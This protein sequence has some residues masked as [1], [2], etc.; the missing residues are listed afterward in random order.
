MLFWSWVFFAVLLGLL[1]IIGYLFPN[2]PEAL[3]NCLLLWLFLRWS[4]VYT[5]RSNLP[6]IKENSS[7]SRL[8]CLRSAGENGIITNYDSGG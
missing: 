2:A 1:L 3:Q 8:I 4:T 6:C 7:G 5:R